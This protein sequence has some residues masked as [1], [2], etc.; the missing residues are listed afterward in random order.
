MGWR[1]IGDLYPGDK[2][3]DETGAPCEVTETF[4]YVPEKA[5][6]LTFSDN[7]SVDCCDDHQWTTWTHRDRKQYLRYEKQT[8]FPE[9]WPAFRG[10]LLNSH[11]DVVG[12]YGP[13]TR[14][15][16]QIV[17]TFHQST[18]RGDLNHCVPLCGDLQ[19][20]SKT[21]PLDP[22]L[23][24]YWLG[25]GLTKGALIS[26]HDEDVAEVRA[27]FNCDFRT[28]D[29]A[30][31]R[32]FYVLDLIPLLR[33]LDVFDNK[34]VPLAYLQAPVSQRR[35][36]LA[37]LLD[38]DGHCALSNGNI[39]FCSTEKILAE[40]VLELARSLSQKPTLAEGRAKLYGV[41]HGPKYRVTWRPTYNPFSLP[42]KAAAYREPAT[43]ALINRHRML[44]EYKRIPPVPM[45]CLTV[46]S[47]NSMFLI[48][49]GMIPT[50]NTITGTQWLAYDAI[51][52]PNAYPSCVIAPTLN[53]VRY[54]CF[55]GH[56]G[57]LSHIPEELVKDYN[58]S[59]LIITLDNGGIIRGFSAE[60]PER[61]RGPQFARGLL[62]ELAAWGSSDEETFDMFMMGL[63][64]GPNPKF[65]VTTTPKPRELIRTLSK[66]KAGR[67]LRS[68]ST[69]DNKA[70]LP[71]SFFKQL[72]KYEGTQLGRQELL[73]EIIDAEEGGI[74]QRGWFQIWPHDKP[75]PKFEW[76]VMSMD[77]AFT[78]S[79]VSTKTH[80]ADPTACVVFGVFWHDDMTQVMCLDSWEDKLGMPDLIKRTKK[81]L[82]QRYGEDDDRPMLKPLHGPSRAT[83]GPGSGRK[84]DL[85]VIEDKGSGISLRQSLEREGIAAYAYNPGR[86]D[87]LARLHIVSYL[88]SQKRVWLPESENA[89]RKGKPKTWTDA[90][91]TQ[92]CS[93]R[94]KNS[95]KHDDHIDAW[96][97]GLRVCLDKGLLTEVKRSKEERKRDDEPPPP[98]QRGNPYAQ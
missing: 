53:D 20:P 18:A 73:G 67:V 27:R 1:T 24:G 8:D 68:G 66:P 71:E 30:I 59:N 37:A 64:L 83:V 35:A 86:A 46:D 50:H 31:P 51:T 12:R 39:E 23:L 80:D 69:Y 38:S 9:N 79:S 40:N 84:I 14:T 25:N 61:M 5:F 78:E 15:T 2:V 91:V 76:L 54:T 70:H 56:T 93:Y 57:I 55:E 10:A 11:H 13:Q 42:R 97:G 77:T 62:E 95:L 44:I 96:T 29:R 89:A 88:F 45:R 3:F 98:R 17:D 85:L 28:T 65:M 34:H 41:D 87:K 94:G 32:E 6:R 21:L 7:T 19:Y 63:R 90:A 92:L 16:Q 72:Q 33:E 48:G 75:L 49:E 4:D 22:W 36:M 43:R 82:E 26:C 58:R 60:E 81:E 47:P 74:I 52:D